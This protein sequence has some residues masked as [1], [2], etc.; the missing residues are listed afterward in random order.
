MMMMMIVMMAAAGAGA[1]IV[2][3]AVWSCDFRMSRYC[4]QV[5]THR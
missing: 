5:G 1:S 2:V 4:Y 3:F